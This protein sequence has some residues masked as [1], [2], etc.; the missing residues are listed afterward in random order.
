MDEMISSVIVEWLISVK[1]SFQSLF[2]F[3]LCLSL[4]LCLPPYIN[5]A[6]SAGVV[7]YIDYISEES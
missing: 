1:F 3:S 5:P 2:Y 7:E 4:S 6:Q